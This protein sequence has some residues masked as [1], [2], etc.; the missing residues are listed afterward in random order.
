MRFALTSIIIDCTLLV[1]Q[2]IIIN[3][4][5]PFPLSGAGCCVLHKSNLAK[6]M[7]CEYADCFP[8]INKAIV[9]EVRAFHFMLCM[10]GCIYG[11]FH[12]TVA[13]KKY[14]VFPLAGCCA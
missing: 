5:A 14:N 7:L 1:S 12:C 10:L 8:H 13:G 9:L 2:C 4:R 11:M 6:V 3:L